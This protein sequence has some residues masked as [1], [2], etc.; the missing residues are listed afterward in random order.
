[1]PAPVAKP[2]PGRVVLGRISGVFGVRGWVK[3]YSE[4]EPR[5]GILRYSPWMVGESGEPRRVLDGRLHGKGVVARIEGCDDRDQAALLV[6]QEI[7]VTRDRLPPPRSDEFYWV[8]LEGL[9]VVTL[10]G[11]VLGTVSHL[12]S[13]GANDVMVVVGERERLIPFTWDTA[14]RS[15]D[16]ESRLIQVDWDPDF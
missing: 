7:A 16:F 4:T 9:Q 14:I 15:V 8:D 2:E 13:T 10:A 11:Q 12:F 6:D 3:I 1:M 5:D